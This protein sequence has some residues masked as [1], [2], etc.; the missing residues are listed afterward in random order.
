MNLP[1]REED[2]AEGNLQDQRNSEV[3]VDWVAPKEELNFGE[4]AGGLT[5]PV[6]I[7]SNP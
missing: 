7:G 2:Q 5:G 3:R 6:S 1:L 4:E